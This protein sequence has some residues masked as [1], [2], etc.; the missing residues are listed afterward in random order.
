MIKNNSLFDLSNRRLAQDCC[1]SGIQKHLADW[2]L[3]HHFR[4][5]YDTLQEALHAISSPSTTVFVTNDP[6]E[7]LEIKNKA[8][9]I[10]VLSSATL[11]ALGKEKM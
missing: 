6:A 4:H 11:E 2:N 3:H 8:P 5:R 7:H 1:G 10:R 9:E